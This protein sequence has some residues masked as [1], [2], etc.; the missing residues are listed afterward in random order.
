LQA[1]TEKIERIDLDGPRVLSGQVA[2][3]EAAAAERRPDRRATR[4]FASMLRNFQD[5][6]LTGLIDGG[7]SEDEARRIMK[8]ESEAQYEAM[9]AV[10]DAQRN[11]EVIDPSSVMGGPQ[12]LLREELGD[13]DYERYLQALGQ[14]TAVQVTQVLEGSPG[15]RAGLQA[16]DQIVS[17]NGERVFNVSDLREL[18]L[19][20]NVGEDVIIQIDRDDV[21]MQLSVPRGPVG[22]TGSGASIRNMNWWG[23]G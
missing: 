13:S 11:G 3:A 14:P 15:S 17:Y 12:S 5:R 16:G 6:R 10:H 23:G 8:Q 4:D 21:R 19:Q 18:T 22:I 7:F 1:L 20:G 2:R 9:Q